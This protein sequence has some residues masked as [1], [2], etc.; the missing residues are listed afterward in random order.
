[1][2]AKFV[3]GGS[4]TG[5]TKKELTTVDALRLDPTN[6]RQRTARGR[7]LIVRSLK[8]HGAA[9]SIVLDERD[10]VIAGNGVIDAATEAG[11]SKVRIIE[12][13]GDEI[14]A[15]RRR[16]LSAAQKHALAI[17][18][19]RTS[20]L[21]EWNMEQLQA[22]IKG[23]LDL[24]PFF[25]TAE[26]RT[27]VGGTSEATGL[28]DPDAVPPVRATRIAIGDLFE[29][30]QHRLLCG[31]ATNADQVARL[32][33]DRT[34]ALMV[35]DPPYGVSY[36]PAW[37]RRAGVNRNV[38]KLGQVTNDDR[39]DWTPA[40]RLFPGCVAYVYYNPLRASTV[41]ISLEQAAFEMRAEIIWAKDRLVLGR[42]DYHWQHESCWY[43]VRRGTAAARSDDRTQTTLWA[44]NARD[45]DGHMHGTQKPVE[46][47]ARPM[48]NHLIREVYDP[49]VGSGTSLIAAEMLRLR[50]FAL[51]IE[52][53]Y[54]QVAIDR[55]EAFTGQKARAVPAA[56]RQRRRRKT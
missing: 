20:E 47:M 14:I 8:D 25:T 6:P 34:P 3:M 31:D 1:V 51:E 56:P 32:F 16:G 33:A 12:A 27:L 24:Q 45:D 52:P 2:A 50:C 17:A 55:W 38:K 46:C 13:R 26:L 54:V 29:L 10:V 35:T 18:D 49:F 36:D 48:R 41:Q 5:G 4:T 11:I 30:G 40:W 21:A 7:D 44:I 9:R 28:T 22:D 23:G 15:V 53:R 42:G 43:A 19:N 39:A 37:R